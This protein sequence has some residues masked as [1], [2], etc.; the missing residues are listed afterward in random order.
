MKHI[1]KLSDG[2]GVHGIADGL[3]FGQ[4]AYLKDRS[5]I[6][7]KYQWKTEDIFPDDESWEKE[8]NTFEKCLI[9]ITS[10]QGKLAES[11]F[12]F[13]RCL[14]T[15]DMLSILHD[16]LSLYANLKFD[17]DTRVA[18]Y[19]AYRDKISTLAVHFHQKKSFIEPEILAIPLE[20]IENFLQ[21]DPELNQYRHYLEN[22]FRSKAHVLSPAEEELLALAGDLSRS[23]YQIFS[24][25]NNADIKFPT[26]PDEKGQPIELTKGNYLIFNKSPNRQ[27]R[28]QAFTAMYKTYQEWTNTLSASLAGAVKK[29][30]F[31]ARARKY[32]TALHAALDQD[33]IPLTVYDNLLNTVN[34][35]LTPLHNYI[36]FRKEMLEVEKVQAWDLFVPLVKDYRWEV[37]YEEGIEL[38]QQALLPLGDDYL[39]IVNRGFT[40]GWFDVFENQGKRSGAYSAATYGVSHPFMLL[41]YQGLLN[42]V[43]TVAHE[44]GHSLHSYFSLNTQPYIYSDYTIF[45]AEVASTLNEALLMDYLLKNTYDQQKKL[46]LLNEYIDQL[47]GTLYIQTIFAEFEKEIHTRYE[48]GEA[49]TAEFLNQTTRKLYTRYYGPDFEMNPL[50][51]IN[52]CRIPHFYY[53][54]YVYQYATG[55]SAATTLAQKILNGDKKAR[56]AYLYFLSRGSA[57]YSIHLLKDAGVDMT[58]PEPIEATLHLFRKLVNEIKDLYNRNG[59]KK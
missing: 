6:D 50:Y 45:V 36:Q 37:S 27:V 35:N 13:R 52:W 58:S 24:M 42:D 30:V 44:M 33:N 23:P 7:P 9:D 38:I 34:N 17:Q 22:L 59:S 5:Q 55:I 1:E 25:F 19:Q 3:T 54:F 29:N 48:S 56:D 26:I 49:L 53:N 43:F 28:E 40:S 20:K 11:A 21:A 2:Y 15:R 41:N 32:P 39:N 4:P 8:F 31:Y 46:Y 18:K 10:F 14:Q 47:R 57:D 16:K 12:I 51:D